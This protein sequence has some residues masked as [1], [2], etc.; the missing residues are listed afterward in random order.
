[1]LRRM[2]LACMLVLV[3]A[4]TG[5]GGG[6]GSSYGSGGSGGSGTPSTSG[7]NQTQKDA[8]A[9]LNDYRKAAL[10][11]EV[12]LNDVLDTSSTRHA[13]YQAIRDSGLTHY[14]TV[15]GDAGGA[16]DTGNAMFSG[17]DPWARMDAASPTHS[18]PDS[19]SEGISSMGGV[20]AIDHLWNT[21]YHR[22]P[23]M[24]HVVDRAGFG[25]RATAAATYPAKHVPTG[26]SYGFATID[27]AASV[28]AITD[29]VWPADRSTGIG[30][31]FSSD[32]ENP[33]PI[34]GAD[35]VGT[36][37]HWIAPVATALASVS[38]T[39]TP[40]GGAAVP[41]Y[42][43]TS[44]TDPAGDLDGNEVFIMTQAPLA[45]NTLYHVAIHSASMDRS[46][47]FSTGP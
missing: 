47:S 13:G 4:V 30:R 28:H 19:Y 3:A 27:F 2:R 6:G 39:V 12:A 25:D 14:E 38:A 5:C 22:I 11:P 17:V 42:L 45:A 1:M 10:V 33:D 37:I 34:A 15:T 24:R 29:S 26:G 32:S 44:A 43:L 41:I 20:P 23:M 35:V 18:F 8:I 16:A 7:G 36:P 9:R 46:W 40:D 31:S 21:V